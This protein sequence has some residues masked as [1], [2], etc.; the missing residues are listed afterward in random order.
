MVRMQVS[1]GS[2]GF[3]RRE[4]TMQ[5][6]LLRMSEKYDQPVSQNPRAVLIDMNGI[7]VRVWVRGW[8][9]GEAAELCSI[10]AAS[11]L[12]MLPHHRFELMS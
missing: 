8:G 12:H 9:S 4:I 1:L 7:R 6:W 10:Q 3:L 2:K 11:R 5:T